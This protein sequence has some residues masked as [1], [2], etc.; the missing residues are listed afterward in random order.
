MYEYIHAVTP[1]T[2]TKNNLQ[3]RACTV[4]KTYIHTYIHTYT[5][6]HN[7]ALEFAEL[8]SEVLPP[9]FRN[10]TSPPD[11]PYVACNAV[12]LNALWVHLGGDPQFSFVDVPSG[13][14]AEVSRRVVAVV[15]EYKGV[16]VEYACACMCVRNEA[17][18]SGVQGSVIEMVVWV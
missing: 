4:T 15:V 14:F 1:R 16:C 9:D 12:N 10:Y 5:V 6:T 18:L 11:G 2:H 8:M 3:K 17:G 7:Q 13:R